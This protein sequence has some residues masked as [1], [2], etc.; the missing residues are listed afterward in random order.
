MQAELKF[1]NFVVPHF[2]FKKKASTTDKS[3]LEIKPRAIISRSKKQFHITLE[4]LLDREEDDFYIQM[5]GVGIFEYEN[6]NEDL[7]LNFMSINGPAIVFPY[8]R[9]FISSMTSLSGFSTV[10]LPT[11]NMSGYRED[12]LKELIDLDKPEDEIQHP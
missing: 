4:V 12:I 3:I 8:L 1:I 2:E 5:L 6:D 10:T 11:L 7:L 9:S